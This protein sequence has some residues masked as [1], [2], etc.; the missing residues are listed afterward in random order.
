MYII[1]ATASSTTKSHSHLTTSVQTHATPPRVLM[2]SSASRWGGRRGSERQFEVRYQ[3]SDH[4]ANICGM[5]IRR[6]TYP[7]N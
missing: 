4:K 7:L 5:F 6:S 1:A 2:I 3:M